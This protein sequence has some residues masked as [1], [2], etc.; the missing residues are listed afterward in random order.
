MCSQSNMYTHTH[1]YMYIPQLVP[2]PTLASGG[3]AAEPA[4]SALS[5]SSVRCGVCFSSHEVVPP[6]EP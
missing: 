1:L 4:L 2:R 6:W 5:I 3:A